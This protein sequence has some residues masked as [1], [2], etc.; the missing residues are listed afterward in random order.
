MVN[1]SLTRTI[2]VLIITALAF[3]GSYLGK[4]ALRVQEPAASLSLASR[5]APAYLPCRRIV[6]LAPSI[7][8]TLFALGLGD[9]VVAVT[10]YCEFPAEAR[11]KARIGGF[12]DANYEAILSLAPDLVIL[13]PEQENIRQ[14]LDKA[15][16]SVL[17]VNNKTIADIFAAIAAIGSRCGVEERSVSLAAD[18]TARR[19][20]I[21]QGAR[22]LSRPRVMVSI[23]GNMGGHLDKI[24]VAGPRTFYGQLVDLAGGVNAYQGKLAFPEISREGL[25]EL[26]PEVIIDIAVNTDYRASGESARAAG[27]RK[28]R[29]AASGTAAARDNRIYVLEKDYMV[30][31]G[32]RFILALED[33]ASVLHSEPKRKP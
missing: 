8:E 9:N 5:K 15:G 28:W 33:I 6:S 27:I 18:L 12:Y 1:S 14:F 19:D 21:R 22:R 24:C 2:V 30:I 23:G 17:V 20:H 7:T 11:K 26:N 3:G 10:R 4:R 16:F 29:E 32:P 25:L 31:P 13:L